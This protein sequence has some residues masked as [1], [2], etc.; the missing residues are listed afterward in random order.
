M[1]T[2]CLTP[3]LVRRFSKGLLQKCEPPS[4][5]MALGTP[6]LEKIFSFKNLSTTL[7]SAAL[8]GTTSTQFDTQFTPTKMYTYPKEEGNVPIKSM[9]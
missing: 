5:I 7:W 6:N 9:P 1:A 2:L 3:Y 8:Q 4:L